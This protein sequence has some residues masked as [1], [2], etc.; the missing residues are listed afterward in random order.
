MAEANQRFFTWSCKGS[1][2]LWSDMQVKRDDWMSKGF[3][4]KVGTD[5]Q[6]ITTLH[7]SKP[8]GC[9]LRNVQYPSWCGHPADN[10]AYK[11]ARQIIQV[12][13]TL[14]LP[15]FLNLDRGRYSHA[16]NHYWYP[17]N[18]VLNVEIRL[19]CVFSHALPKCVCV[20]WPWHVKYFAI[21]DTLHQHYKCRWRWVTQ[22]FC[23]RNMIK[24]VAATYFHFAGY[25]PVSSACWC[26][27]PNTRELW[28]FCQRI[29]LTD[30][31]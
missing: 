31:Q 21:R 1:S 13:Q 26:P 18:L 11:Y 19:A 20:V 3:S 14:R 9:S 6:S 15:T 2:N 10:G 24:G 8:R 25:K 12:F 5:M 16:F 23:A 28:W 22:C 17:V 29:F 30:T 4:V 7:N 27:S